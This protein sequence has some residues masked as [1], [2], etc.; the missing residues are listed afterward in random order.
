METSKGEIT[1]VSVC[2]HPC[3][4]GLAT[5][6]SVLK[7]N[8]FTVN[9]LFLKQRLVEDIP[10]KITAQISEFAKRSLFIG[11]S[12]MTDYAILPKNIAKKI[13][14][15][16]KDLILV[17][18]GIH[19]TVRPA[20]ILDIFDFAVK[21]EAEESILILADE[22]AKGKRVQDIRIPTIDTNY[23]QDG[24]IG[25]T[26]DIDAVPYPDF[27]DNFVIKEG[28]IYLEKDYRNFIG[29]YYSILTS[30]GCP[31]DCTFCVNSFYSEHM[32]K[33]A[34][35]RK[36]SVGK[37]IDELIFAKESYNVEKVA[38]LSDNFLSF[39]DSEFNE[40]TSLYAKKVNLPFCLITS[41]NN[42]RETNISRLVELGL[43]RLS[44][45]IESGSENTLRL[46][47]RSHASPQTVVEAAKVLHKFYPRLK[48]SFDLILDNPYETT[49]DLKKTISLLDAM[50]DS[51]E[52][53]LCSLTFYPGTRLY[54]KA[55]K[56]GFIEDSYYLK[57]IKYLHRLSK[58]F[59][60][61]IFLLYELKVNHKFIAY[62]VRCESKKRMAA[63]VC[64]VIVKNAT[65]VLLGLC[66]L[67]LV[68]RSTR[69]N[70]KNMAYHYIKLGF[71]VIK[72][73]LLQRFRNLRRGSS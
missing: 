60:N 69:G 47:K 61:S 12:I 43:F 54:D 23:Y 67:K 14:E 59:Y 45:G 71:L 22:L 40:F 46:F 13:R 56:D 2:Q 41:P 53:I 26:K 9:K 11:F 5:L 29:D 68:L 31:Y 4:F 66:L 42:I 19:S 7:E 38:F 33:R 39:N 70:S 35:F 17:G 72:S 16:N 18:G 30:R 52:L 55:L 57:R 25:F 3:E 24:Q 20:E 8:G 15:L 50:P 27:S 10:L 6:S 1:L 65:D 73:I 49:E 21:G 37:V 28:K 51:Y 32:N 62:L 63:R 48:Y 44:T 58:S 36:R 34:F 64:K